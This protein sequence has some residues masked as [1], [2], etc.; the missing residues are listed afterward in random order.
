MW[1]VS[2]L[3]KLEIQ[4]SKVL[5]PAAYKVYANPKALKGKYYLFKMLVTSESRNTLF[6]IKVSYRIPKYI[7]WT[8]IE[9]IKRLDQGQSAVVCCYPVFD[10]KIVEKTT[11]STEKTEIRLVSGSISKEED[12]SFEM[13]G[14]NDIVYTSIPA[15]EISG[16]PDMFDNSDLIACFITPEDPII[17]YYTQQ[18]QEKVLKGEDA[19]V[20]KNPKEAVR[21]LMGIYD[22]TLVAHMVYSGT[23][24]IPSGFDDVESIVQHLRLPR[25]VVTGNTGLCIELSLLYASILANEGLSP[26]IYLI[27]GHAY[28][29]FQLG[30][31]YYAIEA[32]SIGG[33]VLEEEHRL[34]KL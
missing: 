34:L 32:T 3:L 25:E 2:D 17:K 7:D 18:I 30:G 12:F 29:G 33:K 27:P 10:D 31:K 4:S 11:S 6:D 5:M 26:I 9:V 23:K 1:L 16:Y 21:F 15:K 20:S 8:E 24:G 19:S 14:R 28:P 22:A 13:K